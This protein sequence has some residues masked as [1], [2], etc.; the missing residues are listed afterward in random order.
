MGLHYFHPLQQSDFEQLEHTV[1]LKGLFEPFK[2]KGDLEEWAGRCIGI[3]DGLIRI[4]ME[5]VLVQ[6]RHYPFNLLQAQLTPHMTGAGTTYLR[7]RNPE[8]TTMGVELWKRCIENKET[9]NLLI[10]DLY[11]MEQQRILLNMQISL[12]HTLARQAQDCANKMAEAAAIY[13]G[14]LNERAITSENN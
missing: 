12:T 3:R 6:A 1:Y 8:R 4:A 10:D 7:W 9:P 11:A 2:G 14:C 13:Q 5:S